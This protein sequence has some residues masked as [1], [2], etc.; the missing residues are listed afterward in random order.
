MNDER[1][2]TFDAHNEKEVL[3]DQF[4]DVSDEDFEEIGVHLANITDAYAIAA[5]FRDGEEKGH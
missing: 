5:K 3:V 4:L 2:V 1:H